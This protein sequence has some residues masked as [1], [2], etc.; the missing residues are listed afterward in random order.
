MRDVEQLVEE[1]DRARGRYLMSVGGVS[2]ERAAYRPEPSRWSILD[3]TEHLVWAEEVGVRGIWSAL[4][5]LRSG[6]PVWIGDPVHRGLSIEQVVE[7]TWRTKEQV[8]EVAAPRWGG[9]L[10]YWAACLRSR[11]AVLEE[12][13]KQLEG[14]DLESVIYP[15]P[16]S[17]PLDARQRLEFLRFHLDRHRAQV[18]TLKRELPPE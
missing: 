13:A 4:D 17:G 3:V 9:S 5:G 6:Q 16:I 15:H 2:A 18:E 14:F 12:L 10:A 8:P 11:Q 7:R 1:V